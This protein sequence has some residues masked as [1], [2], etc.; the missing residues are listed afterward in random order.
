MDIQNYLITLNS[1]GKVQVVDLLLKQLMTYFEIHRV[2]GQLGGKQTIQPVIT[3]SQG[4]AKRTPIQQ[5]ELEYN[6]HMKKYLDKGY[7]KLSEFTNKSFSECT[8]P[9]L[10]EFLGSHKTDANGIIK[11]MLAQQSDKC[12]PN[13]FEKE[14]Y[15][16]RKLDGTRCLLY[17][18][19]GEIYSASRGGKDYDVSSTLIRQNKVLLNWFKQNPDLIL[20]GE[21]YAHGIPLQRISGITRLKTWEERCEILEYWIYDIVSSEPFEERYKELMRLQELLKNDLKVKV[22]DHYKVSGYLKIKKLHDQFVNEGFEGLVMRNPKKEY[23][24]GKRSSLYM[25]KEKNY[26]DS[27]FEIVG[28]EEGLRDEDMVFICKTSNGKQFQAKPIG[29]RELKYEY[30]ENMEQIIGKMATVKFFNWTEDG[31]PSQ[32]ILKTIRDYE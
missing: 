1:R 12:S 2:T 27:E 16:S 26:Q 13:V 25:I 23:G 32:P 9:E 24:I 30:L 10:L 28:F 4:K 5:A 21:L 14:W 17:Y 20:D 6:S 19:D 22:I 18:K 7:K 31:L 11:P 3:V 15:C 29:P 8:E